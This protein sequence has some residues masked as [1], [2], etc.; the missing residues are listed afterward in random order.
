[1]LNT[2]LLYNPSIAVEELGLEL[3]LI[4]ELVNEYIVQAY[5]IQDDFKGL[6]KDGD[7]EPIYL[8][9]H[10]LKGAA[11]N[12][13][14]EIVYNIVDKIENSEDIED[15]LLLF[16]ELY[17]SIDTIYLEVEDFKSNLEK[18]ELNEDTLEELTLE[19]DSLE[20][21]NEND[22]ELKLDDDFI[23]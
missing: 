4:L 23:I 11:A 15:N 5:D 7:K 14:L 12:L 17:Q 10:K 19:E 3:E 6:I 22:E 13:R 2:K 9:T 20:K 1:M 18:E 21:V 8:V 16:N